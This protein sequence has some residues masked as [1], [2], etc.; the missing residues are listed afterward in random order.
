MFGLAPLQPTDSEKTVDGLP[1][2][3]LHDSA[4]DFA[5]LLSALLDYECVAYSSLI[6]VASISISRS[7]F[8]PGRSSSRNTSTI[9]DSLLFSAC[10]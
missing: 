6:A 1:I 4:E 8:N 3:R 2:V 5:Y 9:H 10:R 7:T